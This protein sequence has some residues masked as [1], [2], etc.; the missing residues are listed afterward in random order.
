M[1]VRQVLLVPAVTGLLLTTAAVAAAGTSDP[2]QVSGDAW[3]DLDG[4]GVR[5]DGEPG[6]ARVQVTLRT[7][8]SILD[9]TTTDADGR[10][11]FNNVEPATYD[12]RVEP[13]IDYRVTG[14]TLPGLSTDTGQGTITIT[15][16]GSDLD[17][18]TVGL[19]SPV[20]SGP[21][22]ATTVAR[23]TAESPDGEY[24]WTATVFNFGPDDADGPVDV[25]IVLSEGHETRAID[26]ADWSCE[27]SA[28]IVLCQVESAVPAG[29]ALSPVTVTTG[30]TGDVGA[31]VSVTATAR[32]DG[33]FDAAP[34]NDEAEAS[35]FISGEVAAA[36]LDGDGTGDLTNAGA[37]TSGLLVAAII[38][39]TIGAS[40][41]RT[42][43]RAA[44]LP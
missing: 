1:R 17:A 9:A 44:K 23:D 37:P 4:D 30:P 25:R 27:R 8:A 29:T 33:I 24:R 11:A 34:L 31:T 28:A 43:R 40:A 15:V 6:L 39:L 5:D 42:S 19:G 14:G 32:L 35:A 41:V 18:G 10:W 12:V 2:V 16:T 21:D 26:G 7:S 38:A 36:D 13:P 22:I 3:L 20:T